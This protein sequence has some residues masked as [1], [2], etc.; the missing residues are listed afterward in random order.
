VELFSTIGKVERAEIQYE[1]NGRSR[2]SGVVQFDTVENAETAISEFISLFSK[3]ATTQATSCNMLT[4]ITGKFT[5]YQYG[6]RPLDLSYV[7]YLNGAVP[8][9]GVENADPTAGLTQDQIM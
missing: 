8:S 5:G 1:P 9:N 2:G 4:Y 3:P 7:K 6:G